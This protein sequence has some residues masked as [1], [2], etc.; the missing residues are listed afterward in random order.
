MVL[1]TGSAREDRLVSQSRSHE[2]EH[3]LVR[4]PRL[5]EWRRWHAWTQEELRKRAKVG[6]MTVVRGEAGLPLR[7][8]SV[9]KLARA[10]GVRPHE[11]Q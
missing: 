9:Q 8:S 4:V 10:L 3:V 5:E 11:L 6:R 2:Y 1:Q 7:P